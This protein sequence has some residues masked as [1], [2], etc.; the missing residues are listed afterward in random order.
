[1][2]ALRAPG[3]GRGRIGGRWPGT[4]GRG[5]VLEGQVVHRARLARCSRARLGRTPG[6]LLVPRRSRARRHP[7]LA[8][9]YVGSRSRTL[10]RRVVP[11]GGFKVRPCALG[12]DRVD[13]DTTA[14]IW[15]RPRGSGY[16][17][18]VMSTTARGALA[19]SRHWTARHRSRGDGPGPIAPGDSA[20]S[21]G[22]RQWMPGALGRRP[23]RPRTRRAG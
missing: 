12:Y 6:V 23:R 9:S 14:W 18:V 5:A 15:I 10:L 3:R 19:A 11:W 2:T 8:R 13:L 4:P 1:M 7:E 20:R 22:G 16:D 21:R 17:R